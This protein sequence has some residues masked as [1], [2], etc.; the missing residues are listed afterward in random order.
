MKTT[1]ASH[2]D[3]T[4]RLQIDIDISGSM[5]AV[6]ERIQ[7]AVN[8]L[9]RAATGLALEQFDTD[10]PAAGR[11]LAGDDRAGQM[12]P[13]LPQSQDVPNP[14]RGH[15]GRAECVLNQSRRQGF[16]APGGQGAAHPLRDT[17]ICQDA[18]Q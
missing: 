1:V 8:D 13:S 5:L 7:D 16:C 11:R 4:V 6:E 17:A 3:G 15:V 2:Q 10:L 12:A 18:E 14:L 9:G